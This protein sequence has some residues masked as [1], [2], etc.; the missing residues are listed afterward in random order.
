MVKTQHQG[1]GAGACLDYSRKGKDR[2]NTRKDLQ[3]IK[4]KRPKRLRLQVR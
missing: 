1:H 2:A 3:E 4:P